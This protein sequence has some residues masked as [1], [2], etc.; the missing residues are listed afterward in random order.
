MMITVSYPR[1]IQERADFRDQYR[2][3]AAGVTVHGLCS[4]GGKSCKSGRSE[5]LQFREAGRVATPII[6]LKNDCVRVRNDDS[7]KL[8]VLELI[9]LRRLGHHSFEMKAILKHAVTTVNALET[10]GSTR[11]RKL[12]PTRAKNPL[13]TPALPHPSRSGSPLRGAG[14]LPIHVWLTRQDIFLKT[15]FFYLVNW[16]FCQ[17]NW[18]PHPNLRTTR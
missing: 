10:T 5:R 12:I 3:V 13:L 17:Y 1:G 2:A 4:D 9:L 14:F 11:A 8:I 7:C 15:L 18:N 6:M 16:N